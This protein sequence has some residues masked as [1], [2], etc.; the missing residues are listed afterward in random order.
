[1]ENSAG[2]SHLEELG[3][4]GGTILKEILRKC[5]GRE[6][7]GIIWLWIERSGG[8]CESGDEHAISGFRREVHENCALLCYYAASKFSRNV[9]KESPLLAAS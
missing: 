4:N 2:N 9:G 7:D 6:W 1:V 8:C 3:I 5:D